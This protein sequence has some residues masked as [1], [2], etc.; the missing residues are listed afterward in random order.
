MCISAPG[1]LID[2]AK[3][4]VKTGDLGLGGCFPD[5]LNRSP[6]NTEILTTIFLGG[7]E[8]S[9]VGRVM[10]V[11]PHLGMGIAF[12]EVAANQLDILQQWL[13][14]VSLGCTLSSLP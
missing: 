12:T 6:E 3:F 13:R 5:M 8:F 11:F 2:G 10:F 4:R 7:T 9:G 14:E 1:I